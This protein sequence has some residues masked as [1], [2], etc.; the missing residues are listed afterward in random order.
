METLGNVYDNLLD[1]FSVLIFC[2]FIFS[3]ELIVF[4]YFVESQFQKRIKRKHSASVFSDSPNTLKT[5]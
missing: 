2:I 3:E 5:K 4:Q 1:I